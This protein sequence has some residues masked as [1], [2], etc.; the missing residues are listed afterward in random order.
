MTDV[1]F[2]MRSGTSAAAAPCGSARK[3]ASTAGKSVPTSSSVRARCG[4]WPAIGSSWRSLPA[5]PTRST[6][7]WRASRRMSSAPTY[8]VA[9]MIPTRSRRGPPSGLIPRFERG[10]VPDER[11]VAI[12]AGDSSP[13][14]TG[15][16]GRSRAAGSGDSPGRDEPSSW[17]YDYTAVVHSH[18]RGVPQPFRSGSCQRRNLG[19]SRLRSASGAVRPRTLRRHPATIRLRRT[20]L[21]QRPR[22]GRTRD[23][24]LGQR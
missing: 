12:A 21:W 5:S 4:W 10:R 20:S 8:P 18:A 14:L 24:V 2:A 6:F 23:R 3:A 11:S 17:A 15:T 19:C 9:P 1:P 22:I 13:V 16:R 7:G